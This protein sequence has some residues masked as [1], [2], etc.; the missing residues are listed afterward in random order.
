ME[1]GHSFEGGPNLRRYE[2][3]ANKYFEDKKALAAACG[4]WLAG[5]IERSDQDHRFI[6]IIKATIGNPGYLMTMLG[7]DPTQW[8]KVIK[9]TRSKL[10]TI[11]EKGEREIF[12]K[13]GFDTKV[14]N[15]GKELF[16]S[17]VRL[18]DSCTGISKEVWKEIAN[19]IEVSVNEDSFILAI[20]CLSI[21]ADNR[22]Q[23]AMKKIAE[24][25]NGRPKAA[26]V[27][28]F[29]RMFGKLRADHADEDSPKACANIDCIR[30]GI[31]YDDVDGIERGYKMVTE[32]YKPLR[33][34][35]TFR[36]DFNAKSKT[37]DYQSKLE[38]WLYLVRPWI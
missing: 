12:E 3:L 16:E 31:T 4:A 38:R 36:R 25:S 37:F 11:A 17:K 32:K 26:P 21:A 35:N 9:A 8:E 28:S 2:E 27:K 10:D 24:V 22:F 5:V 7:T 29:M 15:L 23:K 30:L 6:P 14:G 20:W 19:T 1:I 13:H 18:D 33:V 34:K